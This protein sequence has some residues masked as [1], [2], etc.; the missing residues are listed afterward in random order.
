MMKVLIAYDTKYGST[1]DIAVYINSVLT[2][3]GVETTM[4][5]IS[6]DTITDVSSYDLCIIG[7]GIYF[8]KWT[9]NAQ[10]F[11]KKFKTD[12]SK[13]PVALFVSCMTARYPDQHEIAMKKYLQ[14]IADQYL[15]TTPCSLGLFGGVI[16]MKKYNVGTKLLVKAVTRDL[17]NQGITLDTPYDFRDWN[18]IRRW[19]NELLNKHIKK[20]T[21]TQ[22]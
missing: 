10:A 19:T 9:K 7:S 6:K 11:L 12:L 3:A 18:V 22:P 2:N 17:T 15:C 1:T 16:N 21:N 4:I 8:G 13:K 14:N 20:S 5:N